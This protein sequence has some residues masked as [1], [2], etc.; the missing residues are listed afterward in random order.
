M[1]RRETAL[2]QLFDKVQA[3]GARV[4]ADRFQLVR[5]RDEPECFQLERVRRDRC[6]GG[7]RRGAS[8]LR[9]RWEYS[10]Q[11]GDFRGR[12]GPRVHPA[13]RRTGTTSAFERRKRYPTIQHWGMWNEPDFDGLFFAGQ[14]RAI[15]S[16]NIL[17]KRRGCDFMRPTLLAKSLR[18]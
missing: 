10:P 17:K 15:T 3:G 16:N 13:I 4:G 2:T 12:A 8:R 14:A 6:G 7:G 11:V 1:R 5:G 18:A 9:R